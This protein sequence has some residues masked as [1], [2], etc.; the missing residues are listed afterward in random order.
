MS[1]GC[2]STGAAVLFFLGHSY[3]LKEK[4]SVNSPYYLYRNKDYL[5]GPLKLY[6]PIILN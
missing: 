4:Y 1:Y 6:C 3:Y 2:W 5:W